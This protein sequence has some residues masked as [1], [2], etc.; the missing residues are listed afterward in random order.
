[1]VFGANNGTK[2]KLTLFAAIYNGFGHFSNE[3]K[4]DFFTKILNPL[5]QMGGSLITFWIEHMLS[6]SEFLF[7]LNSLVIFNRVNAS[8]PR[9]N[10]FP[11]TLILQTLST[12]SL[13]PVTDIPQT[14]TSSRALANFVHNPSFV[15]TPMTQPQSFTVAPT[16]QHL[17]A[18]SG[19]FVR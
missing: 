7:F 9:T 14:V 17:P 4:Y 11:S 15:R 6:I 18:H 19:L 12:T 2:I 8:F 13:R 3:K 10:L 5:P 1:M 16:V